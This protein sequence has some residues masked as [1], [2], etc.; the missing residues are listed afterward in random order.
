[1]LTDAGRFIALESGFIE[2]ETYPSRNAAWRYLAL[3]Y[4]ENGVALIGAADIFKRDPKRL[5]RWS[6]KDI[7][8]IHADKLPGECYRAAYE[9]IN[10]NN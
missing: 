8:V 4:G 1:M 10:K 5:K 6:L 9:Q 2:R 7:R 3:K